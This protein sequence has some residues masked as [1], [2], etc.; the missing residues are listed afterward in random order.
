M[1]PVDTALVILVSIWSFIFIIIAIGLIIVLYQVKKAIDKINRILA[2]AEDVTEGVS[3]P[4]KMAAATLKSWLGKSQSH[5]H[6]IV[7][8]KKRNP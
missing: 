3:A 4:L 6:Q 1:T 5:K 8:S 2:N 7:A